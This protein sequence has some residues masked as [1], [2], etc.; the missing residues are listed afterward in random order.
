M[1]KFAAMA[2]LLC[3]CPVAAHA[4]SCTTQS[5]MT[6]AQRSEYEQASRTLATEI[7]AGNTAAVRA[8]TIDR[9]S[10]V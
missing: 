5:E 3:A 10:V 2:A 1:L 8:A 9:K 4:V 7:A 6:P